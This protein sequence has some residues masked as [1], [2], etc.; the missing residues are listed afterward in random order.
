MTQKNL[1][2]GNATGIGYSKI[3]LHLKAAESHAAGED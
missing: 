2:N 1:T 3:I